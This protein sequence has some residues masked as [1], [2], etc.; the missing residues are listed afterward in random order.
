MKSGKELKSRIKSIEETSKITKAM[1]LVSI[2]RMRK[3]MRAYDDNR[4][5]F[6]ALRKAVAYIFAREDE[7]NSP[8][9][10]EAKEGRAA[11][12]VIASDKG[13]AGG[14]NQQVLGFA[15]EDMKDAGEKHVIAIGQ[16]ALDF[17]RARGIEVASSYL[18]IM[19]HPELDD[20]RMI[21]YEVLELFDGGEVS[22]VRL[23]FTRLD[24][25]GH[26]LP[27]AIDLLPVN[28][29]AL[30]EEVGIEGTPA[31]YELQ[32]YDDVVDMVVRQYLL[33][34]VYSALIQSLVAENYSRMVA[35]ESATNNSMKMLAKLNLYYNKLRQ[36]KITTEIG[37]TSAF[38]INRE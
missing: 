32:F 34:C 15:L 29:K 1:H 8:Y 36:E 19:H 20:A 5:Y 23:V 14:F 18:D 21:M 3:A 9:V 27:A 24:R 10:G 22:K 25:A 11:Y 30:I 33:G 7:I 37:E 4:L 13:L 31:D 6:E 38:L 12:I 16:K 35:M 28:E 2:A 26:Y 17:F